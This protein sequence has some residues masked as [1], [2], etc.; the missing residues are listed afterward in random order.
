[1]HI[2]FTL[3]LHVKIFML[4][5]FI[6]II[7]NLLLKKK[8]GYNNVYALKIY[9]D[10]TR[11]NIHKEKRQ[12]LFHAYNYIFKILLLTSLFNDYVTI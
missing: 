11:S 4:L 1:M 6:M 5:Y 10:V 2:T 12:W 8:D 9:L 3:P 7:L